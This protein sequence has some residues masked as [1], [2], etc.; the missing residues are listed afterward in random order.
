MQLTVTG[1]INPCHHLTVF[2]GVGTF[3]NFVLVSFLRKLEVLLAW[4]KFDPVFGMD[5]SILANLNKYLNNFCL[6]PDFQL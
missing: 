4:T 6:K 2:L 3:A 1:K 5:L